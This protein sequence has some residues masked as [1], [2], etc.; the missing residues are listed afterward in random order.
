MKI[1]RFGTKSFVSAILF[2]AV[3]LMASQIALGQ[4]VCL[5][6]GTPIVQTGSITAGDTSQTGRINRDGV[7]S[8]CTGGAPTAAPVAGTFSYDSYNYTNPTG[9]EACVT[10]EYD[11]TGCG[12]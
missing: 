12:G 11:M 2:Y 3:T 9:A 8:S 4:Y 5:P 6:N 10:V 1:F 7:P